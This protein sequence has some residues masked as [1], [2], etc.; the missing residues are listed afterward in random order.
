LRHAARVS[1]FT[2]L[3]VN[4]VDTLSGLAEL[5][6][7]EAYE[8]DG[9]RIDAIPPRTEQWADCDPVYRSFDPWPDQDWDHVAET[10]YDALHENARAYLEYLSDELST[11]I[12]AV[13]IG[14]D[15][16]QSI[17]LEEPEF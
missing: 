2:G 16:D 6:V 1:G 5:E 10:G 7:A 12:Y 3:A 17:V 14:P 13:G 8:L 9:E 11:P 4:H 15:R